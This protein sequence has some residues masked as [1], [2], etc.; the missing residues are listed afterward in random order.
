VLR[1]WKQIKKDGLIMHIEYR[2]E[3][4]ANGPACQWF[5]Y[6][7]ESVDPLVV[8]PETGSVV[9]PRSRRNPY[10]RPLTKP[11]HVGHGL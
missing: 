3:N 4:S 11:R 5:K 2:D 8:N 7:P 6:R 9:C 1:E 10:R